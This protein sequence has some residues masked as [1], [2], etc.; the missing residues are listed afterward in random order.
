MQIEHLILTNLIHNED[1]N[2]AA[3]PFLKDDYFKEKS[4]KVI[5]KLITNYV[6]KYNSFPTVDALKIDLSNIDGLDQGIFKS[7]SDSIDIMVPSTDKTD[8]RWL[9][10]TSEK[11]C[12]ERAIYNAIMDSI[13]I[14][15][16]KGKMDKGAIPQLLSDALAVNFDTS[17]GHNWTDDAEARY[18]FYHRVESKIPFN[19]DYFNRITKGGLTRKTINVC[20]AGTGV[21]KSLF[22]CSM[23]S[24][25]LLEG[26]NV[27]YIT[28]EMA[29]EKIAERIDANLLN[30][31]MDEL[32]RMSKD[33]FT[34]KINSVRNKTAG[35][36]IIKEYPTSSAGAANF[37]HLLNELRMKKNFVPDIIYIDYLNICISSKLKKGSVNSYEYVKSIAEELRALAVEFDVP[38]MSAT[39]LTRSGFKNSDP[40]L[41]DT[42]ESFGLPAT[43]DLMFALVNSEEL[44]KLDQLMVK[45]LKNRYNDIVKNKKFVIGIDRAKM[46]VYDAEEDA[47]EWF[48]KDPDKPVMDSSKFG[49]RDKNDSG[50]KRTKAFDISK[51]DDFK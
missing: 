22:M 49:E 32:E 29:E 5:F 4:D 17:I 19:L 48:S 14:L 31:T 45:Q 38:V 44:E 1:F 23:A 51:F 6:G 28:L 25:N 10:D 3:Y 42:S 33:E 47:Q 20:L 30:V 21:G 16:E 9:L 26:R 8:L 15:D 46:R 34:R 18:E 2:K 24:G 41:D 50:R 12:Q 27:L 11:W 40:D 39:Q 35:K 13:K 7:A 37:R 36:L 43:C